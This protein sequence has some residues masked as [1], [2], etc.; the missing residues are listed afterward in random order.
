[1]GQT[2]SELEGGG[3][4]AHR[5]RPERARCPS[6]RR[7]SCARAPR[8]GR[9]VQG[10]H[11]PLAVVL[12]LNR[13]LTPFSCRTEG[14]VSFEEEEE[15]ERAGEGRTHFRERLDGYAAVLSRARSCVTELRELY[16]F[17]ASARITAPERG[18]EPGAQSRAGVEER[19]EGCG[20]S[21]SPAR[22][23][24]VSVPRRLSEEQDALERSGSD[25]RASATE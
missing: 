23:S 21:L 7:W 19:L 4:H 2:D 12:G 1:M 17:A 15:E 18:E 6:R 16:S 14:T 13:E 20:R 9:R 24:R 22:E 25:E 10:Q 8:L 5:L 3:A 11:R